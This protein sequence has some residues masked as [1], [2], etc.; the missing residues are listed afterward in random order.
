MSGV[1]GV[2]AEKTVLTRSYVTP[3]GVVSPTPV[4]GLNIEV[5]TYTDGTRTAVKRLMQAK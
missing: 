5:T 2:T 4:D 3:S 1:E